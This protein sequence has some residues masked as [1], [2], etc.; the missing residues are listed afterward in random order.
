M[1]KQK[2]VGF[3]THEHPQRI[4]YACKLVT[5]PHKQKKNKVRCLKM[6][7][8]LCFWLSHCWWFFVLVSFHTIA[9]KFENITLFNHFLYSFCRVVSIFVSIPKSVVW[10]DKFIWPIVDCLPKCFA[11]KTLFF[12]LF[13]RLPAT[14][15]AV[16]SWHIF[17][18]GNHL[19]FA[20]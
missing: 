17:F 20:L 5:K 18:Y 2:T 7:H 13:L 11:T 16:K 15:F 10:I 3:S 19:L 14:A 1:Q 6:E 12:T 9:R 4:A 8:S